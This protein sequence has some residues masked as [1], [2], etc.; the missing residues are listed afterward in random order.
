MPKWEKHSAQK[1]L[2]VVDH[3]TSVENNRRNLESPTKASNNISWKLGMCACLLGLFG[4]HLEHYLEPLQL[5]VP[6]RVPADWLVP[7]NGGRGSWSLNLDSL[8]IFVNRNATFARTPDSFK[9]DTHSTDPFTRLD[10]CQIGQIRIQK[11]WPNKMP[12]WHG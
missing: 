8:K 9:P 5:F 1:V 3:A 2:E 10:A 12:R 4:K 6:L 11:P 7:F